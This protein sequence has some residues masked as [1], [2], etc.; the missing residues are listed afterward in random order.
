MAALAPGAAGAGGGGGSWTVLVPSA[1]AAEWSALEL[2][3][4][5]A[6]TQAAAAAG[7]GSRG[8]DGVP[9]VALEIA[10]LLAA[11]GA[12]GSRVGEGWR[13][14]AVGGLPGRGT[15][16]G[17]PYFIPIVFVPNKP[18]KVSGAAT[19][20]KSGATTPVKSETPMDKS[21]TNVGRSDAKKECQ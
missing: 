1:V 15:G 4:G 11:A 9:E 10:A 21:K 18:K 17:A 7:S 5:R 20:V 19:P 3:G 16:E 2:V 12:A 14:G 6:G 8:G 13:G